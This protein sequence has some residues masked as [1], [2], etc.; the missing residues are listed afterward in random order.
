[1]KKGCVQTTGNLS[2][3]NMNNR[4]TELLFPAYVIPSLI[5]TRGERWQLLVQQIA[6]L[7]PDSLEILAFTL[8]MVRIGNCVYCNS[9]SYRAMHGCRQCARQALNRFRGSDEDLVDLY[10][11]AKT[12]IEDY[13]E[14]KR[15]ND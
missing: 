3:A 13:L 1:M 14:K 2:L 7:K 12:E 6:L 10:N 4:E 11:S 15:N 8:T 9:D 5:N